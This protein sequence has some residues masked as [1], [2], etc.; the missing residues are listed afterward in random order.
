MRL[1]G[2]GFPNPVAGTQ[3]FAARVASARL[4]RRLRS[5]RSFR[6]TLRIR[7]QSRSGLVTSVARALEIR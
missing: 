7:A 4:E 6:A 5:I 1:D 2:D 3:A